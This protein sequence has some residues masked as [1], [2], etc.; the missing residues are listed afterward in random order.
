LST[1]DQLQKSQAR[2]RHETVNGRIKNFNI[3]KHTYR[4]NL[5]EHEFIFKACAVILQIAIQTDEPLYQISYKGDLKFLIKFK[6][7]YLPRI[8]K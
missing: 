1:I 6:D 4:G 8:N 5:G 7:I 2:A 3:L